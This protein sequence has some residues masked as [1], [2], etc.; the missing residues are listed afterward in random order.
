MVQIGKRVIARRKMSAKTDTKF[1]NNKKS[2][3]NN[4]DGKGVGVGIL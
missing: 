1:I 4:D 2:V 3:N